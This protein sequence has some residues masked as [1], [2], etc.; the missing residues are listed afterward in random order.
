MGSCLIGFVRGQRTEP[1][2]GF[3]VLPGRGPRGGVGTKTGGTH[4][5]R[6]LSS[7]AQRGG[8]S[9]SPP[10]PRAGGRHSGPGGVT[11]VCGHCPAQVT[12]GRTPSQA[13]G[14]S[15]PL[16]TWPR[17]CWGPERES[18]RGG[19]GNS[20]TP[21]VRAAR[22]ALVLLPVLHCPAPRPGSSWRGSRGPHPG[23]LPHAAQRAQ[24]P[25]RLAAPPAG[26]AG[27]SR[28]AAALVTGCLNPQWPAPRP[29][30]NRKPGWGPGPLPA[31]HLGDPGPC[32]VQDPVAESRGEAGPVGEL[33]SRCGPV[34]RQGRQPV[35]HFQ[36]ALTPPAPATLLLTPAALIPAREE[37]WGAGP[38]SPAP[39]PCPDCP[40]CCCCCC[41]RL[42]G[43]SPRLA[44]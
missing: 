31:C 23:S 27:K 19:E 44:G 8:C 36:A 9:A 11:A 42:S 35:N 10:A 24:P 4:V 1:G 22:G 32:P 29:R 14:P 25:L 39:A 34:G 12:E 33:G 20:W 2:R 17:L 15:W 3:W 41:W 21:Q 7:W 6:A 18:R 30:G 13:S 26:R 40:C 38:G 43:P 16:G 37:P 5:P 28:H